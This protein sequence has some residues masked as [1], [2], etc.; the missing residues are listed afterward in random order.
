MYR[1]TLQKCLVNGFHFCHHFFQSMLILTQGWKHGTKACA[2]LQIERCFRFH[3]LI[4][5]SIWVLSASATCEDF[6]GNY[7]TFESGIFNIFANTSG[8]NYHCIAL[9]N[10]YTSS[11]NEFDH[12]EQSWNEDERCSELGGFYQSGFTCPLSTGSTLPT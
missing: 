3:S 12:L 1:C 7:R 10:L 9:L 6:Y 5:E 8:I 11:C 2:L 4:C